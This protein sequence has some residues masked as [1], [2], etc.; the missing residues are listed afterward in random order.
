[1]AMLAN[2]WVLFE[3]T[4]ARDGRSFAW[5]ALHD[6]RLP[7]YSDFLIGSIALR[8]IHVRISHQSRP[9]T[10]AL[11]ESSSWRIAPQAIQI[12]II[13]H[14]PSPLIDGWLQVD[15]PVRDRPTCRLETIGFL[16]QDRSDG[17]AN[18]IYLARADT[19]AWLIC[20]VVTYGGRSS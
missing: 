16:P 13:V 12:L 9:T 17:N 1:M 20:S 6:R 5:T 8:Q 10:C 19:R 3:Y 2:L 15:P 7:N 4:K 14:V 18:D 11:F